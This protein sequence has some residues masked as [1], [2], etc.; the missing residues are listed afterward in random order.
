MVK[1]AFCLNFNGTKCTNPKGVMY[2]KKID[3]PYKEINCP[4]YF[5]DAFALAMTP[6]FDDEFFNVL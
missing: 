5:E 1:C 3:D 2:G 4:E 6:E